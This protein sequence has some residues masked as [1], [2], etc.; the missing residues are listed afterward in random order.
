MGSSPVA[1]GQAWSISA[2]SYTSTSLPSRQVAAVARPDG[3]LVL[4]AVAGSPLAGVTDELWSREQGGPDNA[5]RPW[6]PRTDLLGQGGLDAG[7]VEDPALVLLEEPDAVVV[8]LLLRI[9][10]KVSLHRLRSPTPEFWIVDPMRLQLPPGV[11]DEPE[12]PV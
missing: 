11:V 1:P 10:D 4:F 6:R 9:L 5:W 2:S 12:V 3:P 7:P 8:M